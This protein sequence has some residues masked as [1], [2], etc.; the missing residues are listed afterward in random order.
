[1]RGKAT[2]IAIAVANKIDFHTVDSPSSGVFDSAVEKCNCRAGAITNGWPSKKNG[3]VASRPSW[4]VNADAPILSRPGLVA[5]GS[6]LEGQ[7]RRRR[8]GSAGNA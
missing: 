6:L 8:S 3:R 4:L 2:S 7:S 5:I 1:L